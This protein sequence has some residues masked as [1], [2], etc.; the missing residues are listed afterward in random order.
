VLP[1]VNIVA[2]HQLR[3]SDTASDGVLVSA[4]LNKSPY[5]LR[6]GGTITVSDPLASHPET[7]ALK[8]VG[9]YGALLRSSKGISISTTVAPIL[10]TRQTATTVG[11]SNLDEVV[12]LKFPPDH[13]GAAASQ[14]RRADSSAEVINLADFTLIIDQFLNNAILF[15]TAIASLALLAG[16]VIVANSVALALLERR[17]EIGIQKAVGLSSRGVY[18]Q[19]LVETATVAGLGA[20]V[21][22]LAIAALLVPLGRVLLKLNLALPTPLAL[23]IVLGAVAVATATAALV[24]WGPVRIRPLEVLR[25]E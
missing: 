1:D 16:I 22:M 25:Y 14:L 17:R 4:A 11:G 9:F 5:N 15:L 12:E 20:I 2:G 13:A 8:V 3:A 18:A 24:A 7:V 19:V 23:V 6:L 21:G 10:A